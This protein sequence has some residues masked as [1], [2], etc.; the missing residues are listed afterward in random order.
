MTS[1]DFK[2]SLWTGTPLEVSPLIPLH[3]TY[4]PTGAVMADR[5]C[6]RVAGR[7]YFHPQR[8][9]ELKAAIARQDAGVSP[10]SASDLV[11]W[12]DDGGGPRTAC[13]DAEGGRTP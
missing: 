4:P 7:L 10:P 12:D 6:M 1:S 13:R 2:P 8:L 11:R 5:L 9:A 3:V